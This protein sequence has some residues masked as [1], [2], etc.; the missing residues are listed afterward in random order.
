MTPAEAVECARLITDLWPHPPTTDVRLTLLA[1]ALEA[2]AVF[3]AG[4]TAV[5][6]SV[7]ACVEGRVASLAYV[8]GVSRVLTLSKIALARSP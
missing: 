8:V 6:N 4:A 2:I 1:S 5:E 3:M 7:S